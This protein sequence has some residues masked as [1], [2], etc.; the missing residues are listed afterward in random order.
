[1]F[2]DNSTVTSGSGSSEIAPLISANISITGLGTSTFLIATRLGLNTDVFFFSRSPGI[3]L[4][5]LIVSALRTLLRSV[6]NRD[7]GQFLQSGWSR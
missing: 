2:G 5:D 1:M 4:F 3:D 6:F 7:M